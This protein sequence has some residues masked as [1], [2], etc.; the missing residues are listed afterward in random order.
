MLQR[1]NLT[2]WVGSRNFL[3]A[4]R[5]H[6]RFRSAAER[7]IG[8]VRPDG[9]SATVSADDERRLEWA[10]QGLLQVAKPAEPV[11]GRI[12]MVCGSLQPGG[13][14]RQLANAVRGL[15]RRGVRD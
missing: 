5:E 13:A 10:F 11:P 1:L 8:W 7:V 14:E 12:V 9:M 4:M 2:A 15:A 3:L 6:R